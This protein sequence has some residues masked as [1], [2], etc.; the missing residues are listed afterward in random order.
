MRK[1]KL[2][3]LSLIITSLW[4]AAVVYAQADTSLL[5]YSDM[6]TR[7][8]AAKYVFKDQ[9]L[10]K[11]ISYHKKAFTN[12]GVKVE[13]DGSILSTKSNLEA[14]ASMVS[15][16][17]T[18][19]NDMRL[20]DT[21]PNGGLSQHYYNI[22]SIDDLLACM[23]NLRNLNCSGNKLTTLDLKNNEKLEMLS[24]SDNKLTFLD[25]SKTKIVNRFIGAYQ[26]QP[27]K[28]KLTKAQHKVIAESANYLCPSWTTFEIVDETPTVDPIVRHQVR[29][30]SNDG[31]RPSISE[32]TYQVVSGSNFSFTYTVRIG[33]D[34]T[35][36]KVTTGYKHYDDYLTV[37]MN[38]WGEY[39]VT[40][41]AVTRAIDVR[42]SGLTLRGDV[43]C[44]SINDNAVWANGSS[45]FVRS[46]DAADL[47]IYNLAGSLY[48]QERISAGQV[49]L[50]LPSGVYVVKLGDS[51]T[52]RVV[53][54]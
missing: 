49:S 34:A 13:E 7:S 26:A 29:F 38:R 25:I 39:E 11:W 22:K 54:H 24:C 18:D 17:I 23:P 42:I 46:S 52:Q 41:Y 9:E 19:T 20:I 21:H 4:S 28:M 14:L 27:F 50:N 48:K 16:E 31:V 1:V 30:F 2:L 37:N 33:Y 35:N 32:G 10:K 44:E 12:Y 6:S 51:L 45:L 53:I 3:L 40:V 8:D 15:L 5:S 36:A 43:G 47:R